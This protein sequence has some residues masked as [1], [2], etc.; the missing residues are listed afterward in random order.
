MIERKARLAQLRAP[1]EKKIADLLDSSPALQPAASRQLLARRIH[2]YSG[3]P[4][5]V[6]DYPTSLQWFMGLVEVCTARADGVSMLVS[7]VADIVADPAA[8]DELTRLHEEWDAIDIADEA[9]PAV[10]TGLRH[11]LESLSGEDVTDAYLAA[12]DNRIGVPPGHCRNGWHVFVH[13]AGANTPP[14]RLPPYLVFL[15][16]LAWKLDPRTQQHVQ[17]WSRRRVFGWGR[18]AEL[19]RIQ[20]GIPARRTNRT[21]VLIIQF[22]RAPDGP[23]IFHARWWCQWDSTVDRFLP[24]EPCL[25]HRSDLGSFV[26]RAVAAF[27]T[28][29]RDL[30]SEVMVEFIVPMDLFGFAAD[31]VL[32]EAESVAPKVLVMDYPVVLRSLDRLRNPHW[33]RRWHRRWAS[34]VDGPAHVGVHWSSVRDGDVELVELVELTLSSDERLTTVVLSEPPDAGRRGSVEMIVALRTGLPGIIW[35][36]GSEPSDEAVEAL[37]R[38]VSATP[39]RDLPRRVHDLRLTALRDTRNPEHPGR[40]LGLVWDDPNRQPERGLADSSG[41]GQADGR[42]PWGI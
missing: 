1:I 7:A 15:A 19:A 20:P 36:R 14:N 9:P 34:L 29:L 3:V 13:L 6:Q 25:V 26:A 38:L 23:D 21:T 2:R 32:L 39:L 33:H 30:S 4:I 18:I 16:L 27:E 17:Q 8:T 40:R 22:E 31:Q 5:H 24:G 12:T 37:R 11:D 41:P 35:H 10:W 42:T 28:E